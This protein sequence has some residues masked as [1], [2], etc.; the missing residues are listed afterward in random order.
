MVYTCCLSRLLKYRL[1]CQLIAN[2]PNVFA[3]APVHDIA[4]SKIDVKQDTSV[5]DDDIDEDK[6]SS[7]VQQPEQPSHNERT[8][9]IISDGSP[10]ELEAEVKGCQKFLADLKS[11]MSE[12]VGVNQDA[13]HWVQ[14]IGI[15]SAFVRAI[16]TNS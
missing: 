14:Q 10:E 2:S 4:D 3:S 9:K 8:Q 12:Y 7:T 16:F 11:P 6:P 5:N 15:A 13:R 1:I